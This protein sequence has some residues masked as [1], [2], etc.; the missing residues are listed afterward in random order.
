MDIK[1]VE[2]ITDQYISAKE[3]FDDCITS[4]LGSRTAQ[5]K[6]IASL[7]TFYDFGQDSFRLSQDRKEFVKGLKRNVEF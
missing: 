4:I 2:E 6:W 5:S 3:R 1:N 7:E